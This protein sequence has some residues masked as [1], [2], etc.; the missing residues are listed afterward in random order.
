MY[1]L[2]DLKYKAEEITSRCPH[3]PP[4]IIEFDIDEAKV[5]NRTWECRR[6]DSLGQLVIQT[7]TEDNHVLTQLVEK[8]VR[9]QMEQNDRDNPEGS[10]I[11]FRY[12]GHD[13]GSGGLHGDG[14]MD[15]NQGE[16]EMLRDGG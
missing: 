6:S 12:K 5:D 4:A 1:T 15:L 11:E 3:I 13:S 14:M 7:E 16:L 10:C 9:E 2:D 8:L